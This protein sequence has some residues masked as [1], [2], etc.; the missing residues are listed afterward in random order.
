MHELVSVTAQPAEPQARGPTS[1]RQLVPIGDRVTRCD[2]SPSGG[3][4]LP[5]SGKSSCAIIA[6]V[7]E[8]ISAPPAANSVAS[9]APAAAAAAP[10]GE[11]SH[12]AATVLGLLLLLPEEG[13]KNAFCL[14]T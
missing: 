14:V 9:G 7:D 13:S 5:S 4:Y 10:S 3:D 6:P 2:R 12:A 11:F 8:V 1:T